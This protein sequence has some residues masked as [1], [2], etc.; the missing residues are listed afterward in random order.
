MYPHSVTV[1]RYDGSNFSEQFTTECFIQPTDVSDRTFLGNS[2][3]RAYKF[4]APVNQDIRQGDK[5]VDQHSLAYR[6][7]GI[8]D[9]DYSGSEGADN[10]D[11][12]A[13][14]HMVGIITRVTNG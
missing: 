10:E 12:A 5:L 9:R 14:D 4:F 3:G 11:N 2:I 13:P 1:L 8:I 7:Q 6:I